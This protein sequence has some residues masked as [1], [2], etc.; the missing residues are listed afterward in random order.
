MN[1]IGDWH[2]TVRGK[3]ILYLMILSHLLP[4]RWKGSRE[5]FK[6]LQE[7]GVQVQMQAIQRALH[8]LRL[9]PAFGVDCDRRS[10]PYGY[11]LSPASPFPLPRRAID[12]RNA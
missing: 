5:I 12:G 11:R 3:A 2:A 10:K 6:D 9:E 8:A 1:K 7:D 4:H